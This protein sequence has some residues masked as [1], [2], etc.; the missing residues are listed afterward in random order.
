MLIE[1][2]IIEDIVS[3]PS[4]CNNV[5]YYKKRYYE[6]NRDK[7]LE[8]HRSYYRQN[9]ANIINKAQKRLSATK[10][11]KRNYDKKRYLD[12]KEAILEERKL[13]YALNKK[14]YIERNKKNNKRRY[15]NDPTF[16][17]RARISSEV[18]K[19]LINQVA[20]KGKKSIINYL[21]YS[22]KELHNHIQQQFEPWMNWNN[23]KRYNSKTWD[24][25]NKETWTW[26]IDHIIP[27]AS[28]LYCSMEDENFKK[29]WALENLR[30]Y[31]AK[32]N[33]L[34]GVSRS[35]HNSLMP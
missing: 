21:P 17:I 3:A 30:P 7:I 11:E 8:Q 29:C 20:S 23:W 34:D 28:L 4:K 2:D 19:S 22:I 24:D 25:F 16:K 31:S 27:Q 9:K 35:R 15:D 18:R 32:Q 14:S 6:T 1:S 13:Y 26:N 10:N 33:I 12:N 5:K